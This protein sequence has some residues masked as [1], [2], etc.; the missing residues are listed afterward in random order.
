MTRA[1]ARKTR[2]LSAAPV[3]ARIESLSHDGRGVARVD[4][5]VVFVDGG[6]PGEE[7]VFTYTAMRR[8]YGEARLERI[9][10]PSPDR[11][12]P[13]C[14][15]Y[16]IC[17]GC[18]LQHLRLDRQIA[19][20]QDT[21]LEQFRRIGKVEPEALLP[22]LR[23]AP[24]GYRRKARLGVK[25]VAKKGKVLVGFRE[26]SSNLLADIGLCS[27]LHPSVGERIGELA[28]LIGELGIKDRIPQIEVAV[29]DQGAALVFRA[30]SDPSPDD[31]DRLRN[32]G[33]RHD[34]AIYL[35]RQGPDSV[36]LLFPDQPV[37]L[38]YSLPG[39]QLRLAFAPNE[40][41]QVNPE[42]NRLMVDRVIGLLQL[43]AEQ[44]VLDLFCGLGNFTLPIAQRVQ[45][46]IGVEGESGLVLR[47]RANAAA[48]RIGNA[49]FH[50]ADL[51]RPRHGVSA[52]DRP[53]DRVLLDPPRSGAQE[54]LPF[55]A[56]WRAA[57][58]V[59]VSCNAATLARDAGIL[60]AEH[61]YRISRAGVMDMFPQT[62][63]MES[64]AVFE[65]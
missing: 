1:A 50:V 53:F 32:F 33:A 57:R 29:G 58:I 55:A 46:V 16:S 27:V 2:I 18:R 24:F 5:K 44:A 28:S 7:V 26:K 9:V 54:I 10:S 41:T 34:F 56:R 45:Q 48:N 13:V 19:I 4:G 40:F 6:L 12:E 64:I 35:Q 62:A 14:P 37:E 25:Y 60:V 65:K 3:A 39:H 43:S 36:R 17:G 59:Y 11:V 49:E 52:I 15:A 22:A 42:I 38:S 20:K 31:V 61:G 8:D 47:A 21:L 63:H 23:G 30:L 51:F